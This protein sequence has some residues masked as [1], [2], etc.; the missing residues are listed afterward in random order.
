[1]SDEEKF[2]HPLLMPILDMLLGRAGIVAIPV[3]HVQLPDSDMLCPYRPDV[4]KQA[5]HPLTL[6][7]A[8]IGDMNDKAYLLVGCSEDD[9]SYSGISEEHKTVQLMP[10]SFIEHIIDV[11]PEEPSPDILDR[12]NV[13]NDS[14]L[15]IYVKD[16]NF[17]GAVCS[18]CNSI[19]KLLHFRETPRAEFCAH[20]LMTL[21]SVHVCNT[22]HGGWE[23]MS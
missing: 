3:K 18:L 21:Y 15:I 6:T 16:A 12:N 11:H 13:E 4:A 7:V 2:V 20:C 19:F 5:S 23:M 1:M 17:V 9:R 22:T 8:R 10:V 14:R